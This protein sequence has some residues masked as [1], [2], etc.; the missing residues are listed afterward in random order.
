MSKKCEKLYFL[1]QK[2]VKFIKLNQNNF[3]LPLVI[4][5]VV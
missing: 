3:F 5:R 2:N 4:L 1:Y